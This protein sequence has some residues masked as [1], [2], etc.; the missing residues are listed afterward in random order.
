MEGKEK[1]KN[2][3]QEGKTQRDVGWGRKL[4]KKG[5]RKRGKG[6]KEGRK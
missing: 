3:R 5:G 2:K 4:E 6:R 1:I